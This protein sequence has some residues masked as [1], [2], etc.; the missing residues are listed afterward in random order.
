M[1]ELRNQKR[2]RTMR[3]MNHLPYSEYEITKEAEGE[4]KPLKRKMMR[5]RTRTMRTITGQL[6]TSK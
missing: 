4:I 3:W 5:K 2:R 1:F 6:W